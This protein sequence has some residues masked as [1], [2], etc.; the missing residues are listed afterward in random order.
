[1]QLACH[2]LTDSDI[3]LWSLQLFLT[4]IITSSVSTTKEAWDIHANLT[5][6]PPDFSSSIHQAVLFHCMSSQRHAD[7]CDRHSHAHLNGCIEHTHTLNCEGRGFMWT[8]LN[9]SASWSGGKQY[10]LDVL[11]VF[12]LWCWF[13]RLKLTGWWCPVWMFRLWGTITRPWRQNPVRT[14]L[15][16]SFV[17]LK[18][19]F[20]HKNVEYYHFYVKNKFSKFSL[21]LKCF[22]FLI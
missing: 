22:F 16:P 2:S 11:T 8:A 7:C 20:V 9:Q 4:L 12:F 1:M 14:P 21:V 18:A 3:F 13:L 17:L 6:F 10:T 5:S 19:V 15:T